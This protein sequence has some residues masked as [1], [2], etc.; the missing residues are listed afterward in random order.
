MKYNFHTHT[1]RCNHA[2]GS[3]E[4]YIKVAISNG[5]KYMGFSE[6]IPLLREDGKESRYRLP[7]SLSK[8]YCDTVNALKE[9]Y[10]NIIEISLGFEMEYYP[11]YFDVMLNTALTFNAEYLILGQHFSKP[12]HKGSPHVVIENNSVIALEEYVDAVVEGIKTGVFTYVAHPDIFNFNG[13]DT[14]YKAV[15]RK[16]A[17][18]SKTYNVPLEINFLGIREKRNYPNFKFWEVVGEE[19]AP[20]TFGFDSHKAI[21]AY[22]NESLIIAKETVKKYNLNYIGKPNLIKIKNK[23]K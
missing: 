16:I 1:F 9:K 21:D 23:T 19:Q 7:C 20:V 6:H 22:D 12:E 10:N 14:A 17:V 3:E 5:V 2:Q 4:E 8:E 11:E 18:A 13:N 15:M